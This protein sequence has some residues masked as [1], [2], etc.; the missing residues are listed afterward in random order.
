LIG[1]LIG[2][3]LFV[4]FFIKLFIEVRKNFFQTAIVVSFLLFF[5]VENIFYRQFG[6]YLVGIFI[7]ILSHIKNEINE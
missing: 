7:L 1:G 4:A 3:G 5:S 2:L 6:C